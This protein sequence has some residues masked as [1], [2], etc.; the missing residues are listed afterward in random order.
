[1]FE[2]GREDALDMRDDFRWGWIWPRHVDVHAVAA[3]LE[4]WNFASGVESRQF[5]ESWRRRYFGDVVVGVH[6]FPFLFRRKVT[7]TR[8]GGWRAETR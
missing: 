1:M 6:S 4:V 5:G 7:Q 8:D 2:V 3:S